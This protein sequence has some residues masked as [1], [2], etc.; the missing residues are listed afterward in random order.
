MYS[1]PVSRA[2]AV[3]VL[4]S[5]FGA[6][7]ARAAD[8]PAAADFTPQA[9]VLFRVVAC[10][11]DDPPPA[12]FDHRLVDAHCRELREAMKEYRRRWSDKAT[13]FLG[14][15]VPRGLP[16]KVVYPFGGGDLT[17]A[18]AT[19][20]DASEI[21]TI[22]LE[23]AGDPR[24]I[25]TVKGEPLERSLAASRKRI[26]HLFRLAHSLTHDMS[27]ATHEVLPGQLVYA[28]VA[29]AVNGFEP[30]SLRYL[31]LEPDGA[32]HYLDD[33][34]VA[35]ADAAKETNRLFA[36]MEMV[37]KARGRTVTYRHFGANLDDKHLGAD[38]PLLKHLASKGRVVAM[39]K[40]ASYLLW[41]P[42]F[43]KIR[44]YLLAHMDWM[45][46]DSTG[47]PPRFARPAG[48]EYVTYG[49][50]DGPF[51]RNDKEQV[52]A[53]KRIWDRP[54]RRDLPFRFGYPDS[55]RHAHLVVTRRVAAAK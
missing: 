30:V 20:P 17:T 51:F 3:S 38:P 43:S 8:V 33:R 19:F 12:G 54:P 23:R 41:W 16:D 26:V 10:G 4:I 34:E 46:S 14:K 50:F 45:I 52:E 53:W 15:I 48:F 22:S 47:I 7:A 40:A 32:I 25:D 24:L 28:L 36:N 1:P 9:K 31:R 27:A 42:D 11:G 35:A 39:T 18:L 49:R 55:R 5:L 13:P 29:L 2:S 21:T 37:F 6:G 44:N